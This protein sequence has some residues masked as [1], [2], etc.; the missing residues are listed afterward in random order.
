M[1]QT[2][3]A[4]NFNIVP[5]RADA[6]DDDIQHVFSVDVEEWFQVG[7]F[8]NTLNRND[9]SSLDSRVVYQTE[10][11]LS[12][13]HRKKVHATFFCLGWVAEREPA[14]IRKISEAG[15]EVACHGMDHKR[16]YQMTETEFFKD[17][18]KAKTLL[19]DA[20]G[21]DVIGYRAPSFSMSES[22]WNFYERMV[23]AGF[24]Y[25]SSVV[26]AKTDHYGIAGAPRVPFYPLDGQNF[27]EVPMTVATFGKTALPASGGGYFR[28][29]PTFLSRP[30][31]R[32][33]VQQTNTG[34]IFYMHPWEIDP[35]QPRVKNA[36]LRS[37][38]RHYTNQATMESKLEKLLTREKFT[39]LDHMLQKQF[40]M[41]GD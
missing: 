22:T 32:R 4:A 33:A 18:K 6:H 11:I 21:V 37:K 8:E 35:E 36:P 17:I 29:L 13:L 12:L 41:E 25:S 20:C 34:V 15:H 28:L 30:L 3:T 23:E 5:Q 26:P 9:W 19:E 40:V 7:A 38:I 39:R 27:I 31:M 1:D 14:L 2:V 10:K 24:S 16:L